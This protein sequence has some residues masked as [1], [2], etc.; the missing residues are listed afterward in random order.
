MVYTYRKTETRK[1]SDCANRKR[2]EK[3]KE[4]DRDVTS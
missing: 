1:A 2:G 3:G 4:T